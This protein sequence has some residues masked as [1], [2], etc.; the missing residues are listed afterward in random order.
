MERDKEAGSNAEKDVSHSI[1]NDR[2]K[3]LL[4]PLP[5]TSPFLLLP[6]SPLPAYLPRLSLPAHGGNFL[7]W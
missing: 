5:P 3:A 7:C 4:P 1:C 2:R 6:T